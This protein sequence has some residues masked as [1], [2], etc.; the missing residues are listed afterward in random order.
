M[1]SSQSGMQGGSQT[2]LARFLRLAGRGSTQ[3]GVWQR[4]SPWSTRLSRTASDQARRRQSA[5][6]SSVVS[7]PKLRPVNALLGGRSAFIGSPGNKSNV[8]CESSVGCV[9]GSSRSGSNSATVVLRESP[10]GVCQGRVARGS[11]VCQAT[12]L[13]ERSMPGSLCERSVPGSWCG[14][15]GVCRRSYSDWCERSVPGWAARGGR[16]MC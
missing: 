13:C 10:E 4:T 1:L 5:R 11:G 16:G 3:C 9:T 12:R 7:S 8:Y 15:R 2:R 6:A 14:A